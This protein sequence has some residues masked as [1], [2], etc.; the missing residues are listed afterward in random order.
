MLAAFLWCVPWLLERGRQRGT[1]TIGGRVQAADLAFVGEMLRRER[2][3]ADQML[4]YA[5]R[6]RDPVVGAYYT[7]RSCVAWAA[8]QL[9]CATLLDASCDG[10]VPAEAVR[11]IVTLL[12]LRRDTPAQPGNPVRAGRDEALRDAVRAFVILLARRCEVD[13]GTA[14]RRRSTSKN[15]RSPRCAWRVPP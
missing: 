4:G 12:A 6:W 13:D 5:E 1:M 7:G 15:A 2:E 10:T 9:V 3:H 11:E 14:T 8:Y